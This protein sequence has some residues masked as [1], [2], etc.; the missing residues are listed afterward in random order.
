MMLT[1]AIGMCIL[2]QVY[3]ATSV[4]YEFSNFSEHEQGKLYDCNTSM[5][6]Y[7]AEKFDTVVH[8]NEAYWTSDLQTTTEQNRNFIDLY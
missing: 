8:V 5:L 7:V 2:H 6:N 3:L 4:V 1:L